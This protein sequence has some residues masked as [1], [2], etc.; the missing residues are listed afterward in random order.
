M[1]PSASVTHT[2]SKNHFHL[3]ICL[4]FPKFCTEDMYEY[5][6]YYWPAVIV[7]WSS[8]S[9]FP[10]RTSYCNPYAVVNE[11]LRKIYGKCAFY[12]LS[13]LFQSGRVW[14]YLWKG[15]FR[16]LRK[17]IL[18][19]F[20]NMLFQEEAAKRIHFCQKLAVNKRNVTRKFKTYPQLWQILI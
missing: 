7:G 13:I 8:G 10:I 11:V 17:E 2:S 15:E 12:S 20:S 1:I 9:I 4:G 18:L 16:K 14:T 5:N 6:Y 3:K 19:Q